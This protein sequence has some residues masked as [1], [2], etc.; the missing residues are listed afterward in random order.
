MS[1]YFSVTIGDTTLEFP[2][3]ITAEQLENLM[4]VQFP[5]EGGM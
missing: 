5:E 1:G 2:A 3:D 4:T